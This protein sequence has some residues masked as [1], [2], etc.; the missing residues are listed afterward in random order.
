MLSD[1]M[2]LLAI[3]DIHGCL[4]ALEVLLKEV[5]PGPED[6]VVTLGD[7]V[8]RGPDSKGVIDRLLA[9]AKE[10]K[11]V[12][13]LGNHDQMFLQVLAGDDQRLEAWLGVGG[14]ETLASYNGGDGVPAEHH[15]FLAQDC[16][17]WFE[18]E[19]EG[20]FFVHGTASPVL[21]LA[22]QP[23]EW[24][25]WRRIHEART[26]HCSG[27]IMV[28][29]HTAQ[30]SGLPLV[31]PHALCIDTWVFGEGWLTCFDVHAGTFIQAN[32]AG[33]VRRLR[34]DDLRE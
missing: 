26:L 28:C 23:E 12:P 20:V 34:L 21:P 6:T 29:G 11:L 31:L 32:Q 7:Y 13:L 9:L 14:V 25:L 5:R 15:R 1:A 10:T 19:G 3:G 4:T 17:L 2:R 18:P 16:R 30:R 24:L 33:E 22:E 27:R 8:D